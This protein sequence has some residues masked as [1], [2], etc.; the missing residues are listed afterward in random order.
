[1]LHCAM[2]LAT[3]S[4]SQQRLASIFK[5]QVFIGWSTEISRDKLQ[6]GCYIHCTMAQKCI[7]AKVEPAS[8]NASGNKNVA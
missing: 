1:M 5:Q 7:A 3:V 6:E 8:C 2:F 4:Q